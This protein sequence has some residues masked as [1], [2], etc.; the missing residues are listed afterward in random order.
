[1]MIIIL[2]PSSLLY[3]DGKRILCSL[4]FLCVHIAIDLFVQVK[5]KH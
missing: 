2:C 1:M 5:T 4:M 3:T